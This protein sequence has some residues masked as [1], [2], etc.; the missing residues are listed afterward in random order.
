MQKR[1]INLV[2]EKGNYVTIIT[3]ITRKIV[4]KL[5]F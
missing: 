2:I 4:N 3:W 5:Y 1:L